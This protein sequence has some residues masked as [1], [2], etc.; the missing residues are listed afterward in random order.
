MDRLPAATS[1]TGA[2][3][4]RR[5]IALLLVL[6][7]AAIATSYW[8]EIVSRAFND[9]DPIVHVP[10]YDFFQYYAGGHNWNLGLDPYTNHPGVSGAIVYP[11]FDTPQISG[12]I[13]PPTFLPVYG[14]LARYSYDDAR[15]A[16]LAITLS[17]FALLAAVAAWA[18]PGRRLEVLGVTALLTMA[19]YP[20]IY[21]VHN[22]QADLLAAALAVSGFLLYPRW[23]GWPS[24]ALLALAVATK[25]T[26]VLLLAVMV[27]YFRD[28]RLALKALACGVVLAGASLLWL[29]A[30]LYREFLFTTLP[31]IAVSDPSQFNQTVLR[32]WWKYPLVLKAASALGYL[33]LLFLVYVASRNRR[34][35]P[36]ATDAGDEQRRE[37]YAVLLL[38]VLFMLFFSPLAWQMAYVWPI[39]PLALVLTARPPAGRPAAVVTTGVAAALLSSRIFDVRVLD[40]LNVLGAAVAIFAL[41]RWYL[42]LE[43]APAVAVATPD[44]VSALAGVGESVGV[45]PGVGGEPQAPTS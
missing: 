40:L 38:T 33:A 4:S 3:P 43:Q 30:G 29:N 35:A 2:W 18:T 12:Y 16:W 31:S 19:S 25:V 39:V 34:R 26:P 21:H 20:F 41:M 23:R 11:R 5:T 13:Y 36:F 15:R 22:G 44:A 6:L 9:V 24:A 17:A 10:N 42:P 14:A 28:W 32:F 8:V 1:T 7:A 27:V 45:G 37:R